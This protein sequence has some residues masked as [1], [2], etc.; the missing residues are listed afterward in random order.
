MQ[1]AEFILIL[2]TEILL[3]IQEKVSHHHHPHNIQVLVFL[4]FLWFLCS[5]IHVV[6]MFWYS[7]GS[8]FLVWAESFLTCHSIVFSLPA[9][10]TSTPY[11]TLQSWAEC[12]LKA[13]YIQEG[14]KHWERISFL[15]SRHWIVSQIRGEGWEEETPLHSIKIL[16]IWPAETAHYEGATSVIIPFNSSDL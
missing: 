16:N 5:D 3:N 13:A 11:Q 4:L 2:I 6:L 1:G 10:S 8:D 9:R 14:T 12:P 7:C 15:Q